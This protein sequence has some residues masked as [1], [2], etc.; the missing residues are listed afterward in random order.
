M[1]NTI[2]SAIFLIFACV[3]SGQPLTPIGTILPL[4]SENVFKI[5]S[6]D[7]Y[8]L[9]QDFEFLLFES[10]WNGLSHQLANDKVRMIESI[11][12]DRVDSRFFIDRK[13]L[14]TEWRSYPFSDHDHGRHIEFKYLDNKL[15]EIKAYNIA[16]GYSDEYIDEV[17]INDLDNSWLLREVTFIDTICIKYFYDEEGRLINNTISGK[18]DTMTYDYSYYNNKV[19]KV[20]YRYCDSLVTVNE[21]KTT[22]YGYD[23]LVDNIKTKEF[24][25]SNSKLSAIHCLDS[26]Y[27]FITYVGRDVYT[28][29]VTI[30]PF[31]FDHIFQHYNEGNLVDYQQTLQFLS[32]VGV[33]SINEYGLIIHSIQGSFSIRNGISRNN[34]VL[35]KS[36]HAIKDEEPCVVYHKT[37]EFSHKTHKFKYY[38]FWQ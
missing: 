1:K 5:N 23:L 7:E 34:G 8:F 30:P 28:S 12:D 4:L 24:W 33:D 32:G 19:S 27:I 15:H 36:M 26:N 20:A 16:R 3:G 31:C 2:I 21:F 6:F 11:D 35:M 10:I 17:A 38:R 29:E 9:Y 14:V 18:Y 25:F 13:G 37:E 22:I